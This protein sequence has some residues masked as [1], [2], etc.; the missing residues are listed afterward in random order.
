MSKPALQ[1]KSIIILSVGILLSLLLRAFII[2]HSL[3]VAD[4]KLLYGMGAVVLEGLNPFLALNYNSY[5]PLAIYLEAAT[6][7]LSQLSTIPFHI[8]TRVWPNIADIA[9]ALLLYKFLI[10]L[11]VRPTY[12]CLWSLF[13]ILNP[14]SLIIS[15]AH[16]QIDSIS[17]LFVLISTYLVTFH[18]QNGHHS[19]AKRYIFGSA[20]ILGMAIAIKPNPILLL[21]F[22]LLYIQGNFKTKILFLLLT[23][24][25]VTITLAPYVTQN[26]QQIIA[27]LLGYS[28]VYDF[29][30][31]AVLKGILYQD[32]ANIWL[33]L[34][35]EIL[36]ASKLTFLTGTLFLTVF[37][38][39]QSLNKPKNPAY[40]SKNLSQ[41][42]L[43]IY[44]LFFG[45]YFGISAQY[46]TWVLPFAVIIRSKM[47]ILFSLSGFISLLGFY[48]F[49]GPEI[50]LGKFSSQA[51]F[52]SKYMTIYVLGNLL[53][54]VTMTGWLLKIIVYYLRSTFK[55]QNAIHQAM[56]LFALILFIISLSP[57][58][59]LILNIL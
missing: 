2:I 10:N 32:N 3:N 50:L 8:L 20:V 49:F 44:L 9:I 18:N 15:A 53:L 17:S 58:I 16:G 38:Y 40:L 54:W 45:V 1:K 25:P 24:A 14:I 34:N 6:I 51:A 37:F 23:I 52:Q 5:P 57:T 7:Y 55:P 19:L 22:F 29:S 48:M 33:P 26:P 56:I 31:A 12:A 47:S 59:R 35:K 46:L 13:F 28:G 4:I 39:E 27:N 21:P 11:R 41:A 36:E 43:A 30:Y 42:F